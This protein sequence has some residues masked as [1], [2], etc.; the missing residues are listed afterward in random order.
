MKSFLEREPNDPFLNYAMATELIAKG[1]DN[2]AKVIFLKLVNESPEY[3]ATYY[4]LAK[5]Y[6]RE[7]DL[8]NAEN[9]YRTGIAVATSNK[10]EHAKRELQ[11]ALNELL[12]ED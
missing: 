11:N 1:K 7:G 5:L 12:F 9:T 2:D 8:D 3:S 6:E 4:H 10:E